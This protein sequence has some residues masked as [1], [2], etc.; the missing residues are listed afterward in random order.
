MLRG[1]DT[2]GRRLL[3]TLPSW[4]RKGPRTI[5][6][7]AAGERRLG[8]VLSAALLVIATLAV[9]AV[10]DLAVLL[11]IAIV[12]VVLLGSANTWAA[13]LVTRFLDTLGEE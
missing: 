1:Q 9:L 10:A 13:P 8:L 2:D 12:A 6:L 11:P 7:S 3:T 4:D 5:A